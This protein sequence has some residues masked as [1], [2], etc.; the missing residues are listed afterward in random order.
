MFKSDRLSTKYV[1]RV[2]H[3]VKSIQDGARS[4]FYVKTIRVDQL[5]I[6]SIKY[7]QQ[8]FEFVLF[9]LWPVL[10]LLLL[11]QWH[12]RRALSS[13]TY[14]FLLV[15]MANKADTGR[16][17]MY[18]KK[19]TKTTLPDTVRR[20]KKIQDRLLYTYTYCYQSRWL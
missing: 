15:C 9:Q 10:L 18:S 20:V 17:K 7:Y 5:P 3:R 13:L 11:L 19:K 4:L 6:I 1:S 2:F 14:I 8:I 12:I 16:E